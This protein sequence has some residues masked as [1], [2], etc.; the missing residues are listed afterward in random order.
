MIPAVRGTHDILPGEVEKWQR[1]ERR[2]AS[3]ASATGTSRCVR[4]SSSAKSSSPRARARRPTSFRK[5][6]T[7]SPTRAESASRSGPRRRRAWCARS[8]STA[9]SRRWR[10]PSCTRMGPMFRYERP[11]KGRYRQ[12]HQLDVEVFGVRDPA[13]DAE[14]IDLAWTPGRVSSASRD[15]ELR[16]Q[17]GR[18]REVPAGVLRRRS[19][20]ALGDER[21]EA[22]RGLP[23]ARADE[24]A[25]DL[26]LQGAGGPA[27]HRSP[28]ARRWTISARRARRT[29]LP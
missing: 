28:A 6:C 29:S 15:A 11:Q 21:L 1:V 10:S 25:A 13:V 17:L 7:P 12:F 3:C 24:S 19:L 8:S 2:R 14:V 23:A 27:D 4:R 16:H 5:R 26:R 22:V 18:L 20:E 9:S